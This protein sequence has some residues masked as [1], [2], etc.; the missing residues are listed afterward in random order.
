MAKTFAKSLGGSEVR[1]TKNVDVG[2]VITVTNPDGSVRHSLALG[3]KGNKDPKYDYS[4]E[5]VVRDFEGNVVATQ[6][7]GFVNLVDPRAQPD[8]L[9]KAGLISE[10]IYADMKARVAKIPEKIAFTAQVRRA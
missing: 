10:D 7:D 4:V 3:R 9:L 6:T 8:N 2:N 1:K 5:L